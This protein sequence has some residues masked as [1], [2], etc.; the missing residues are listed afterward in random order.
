MTASSNIARVPVEL[1]AATF[2]VAIIALVAVILGVV[3]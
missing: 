1:I 3:S 2:G